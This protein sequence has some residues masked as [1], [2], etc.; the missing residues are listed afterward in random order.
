MD[1][2]D[3]PSLRDEPARSLAS[4][5]R[6]TG[7]PD[8]RG[9][10]VRRRSRAVESNDAGRWEAAWRVPRR[11]LERAGLRHVRTYHEHFENPIAG[12]EH[13]EVEYAITRSG[14]QRARP[15]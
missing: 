9:W 15:A 6:A 13:G 12:T 8:C 3:R 1:Q 7:K 14:W 4:C 10:V 5:P 11:V 2:P